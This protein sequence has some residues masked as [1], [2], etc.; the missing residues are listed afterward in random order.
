ME[1]ILGEIITS[2]VASGLRGCFWLIKYIGYERKHYCYYY[3]FFFTSVYCPQVKAQKVKLVT[4]VQIPATTA[5]TVNVSVT[6]AT[7]TAA[8]V[9]TVTATPAASTET[10]VQTRFSTHLHGIDDDDD[11]DMAEL[12]PTFTG[13]IIK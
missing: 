11:E 1:K 9:G 13:P 6:T 3:Y 4:S 8:T 12:Q 5:T 2:L 10:T 7:A